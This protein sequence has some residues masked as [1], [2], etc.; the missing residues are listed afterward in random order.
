MTPPSHRS[1]PPRRGSYPSSQGFSR[2]RALLVVAASAAL[3]AGPGCIS[4]PAVRP[5]AATIA[6]I[7]PGG[8]LLTLYVRVRNDNG[9][10]VRVRGI[11]ASVVIEKRYPLP[12][13][14]A[15]PNVWIRA[16]RATTLPVQMR[17]PFNMIQPLLNTTL[18]QRTIKYRVVGAADVT[19][20]SS[21][22]IDIDDYR[23]D[24]EA[25]MNRR[26]LAA[27]AVNGLF[28]PP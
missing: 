10:D 19:A 21:L 3:G 5:Q 9:F 16:E 1:V 17:I 7:D 6:G 13:I 23:M 4:K 27:M 11:R 24:D 8:V 20:T 14:V 25:K 28:R 2:R 26:E 18:G 15:T 22:Q 12:P